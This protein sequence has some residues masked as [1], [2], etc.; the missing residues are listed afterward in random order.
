MKELLSRLR[1]RLFPPVS[2]KRAIEIARQ[3]C[4][5]SAPILQIYHSRPSNVNA[6]DLPSE[7]CW[8]VITSANSDPWV[9]KLCSSR[10][11]MVSKRSGQVLFDGSAGDEG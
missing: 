5:E 8:Y 7:D 2:R 9:N 6:Y 10:L 1:F 3:A 11:L 4:A